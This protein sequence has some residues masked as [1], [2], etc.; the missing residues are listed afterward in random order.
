VIAAAATADP[1]ASA[2]HLMQIGLENGAG[3][4]I[5]RAVPVAA[6]VVGSI[7]LWW[8]TRRAARQPATPSNR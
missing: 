8:S 6:P 7:L 3:T 5:L 1:V 4:T 2:L